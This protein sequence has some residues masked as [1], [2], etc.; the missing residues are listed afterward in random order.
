MPPLMIAQLD[1]LIIYASSLEEGKIWAQ[2]V[3]G[4]DLLTGEA[5]FLMGTHSLTIRV[6]SE[7]FPEAYLEVIA[8]DPEA[9]HPAIGGVRWFDMDC[10]NLSRQI[11]KSPRLIHW[12]ARTNQIQEAVDTLRHLGID[13]GEVLSASKQTKA[14]LLEWQMTVRSDGWRLMNGALPTLI[15]WGGRHL[16]DQMPTSPL[17][18]KNI[19]LHVTTE[20]EKVLMEEVLSAIHMEK[21]NTSLLKVEILH[22]HGLSVDIESPHG[23][24]RLRGYD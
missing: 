18:L 12:V 20:E 23:L 15:Q 7:E 11:T 1:H 17:K 16:V 3:L 6:D 22:T 19:I 9:H 10:P 24:V 21:I 13:R 2:E 8:I 14:G 4:V 5:H